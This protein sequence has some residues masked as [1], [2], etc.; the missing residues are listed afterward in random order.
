VGALMAGI[1]TSGIGLSREGQIPRSPILAGILSR[2]R[3]HIV[4]IRLGLMAERGGLYCSFFH[5]SLVFYHFIR[6]T[7]IFCRLGPSLSS[8]IRLSNALRSLLWTSKVPKKSNMSNKP[9]APF[10]PTSDKVF[11]GQARDGILYGLSF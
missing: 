4:S 3:S 1:L 6:K 7:R 9:G 2:K 10:A 5:N 11:R 8:L